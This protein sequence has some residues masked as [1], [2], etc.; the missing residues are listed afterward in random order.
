MSQNS[1]KVFLYVIPIFGG[2]FMLAWPAGLQLTFSIT[3]LLAATQ[4][5]LF[6]SDRF[7]DLVGMQLKPKPNM[8]NKQHI[9]YQAPKSTPSKP[10]TETGALGTL[11]GAVSDIMKVGEKYAPK[12]KQKAQNGRLTEAEKRYAEK[13]EKRRQREFAQEEGMRREDQAR[14]ERKQEQA[15]R[16]QEREARLRRRAEKK[17]KRSQ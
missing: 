5:T 14:S 10:S 13:Y 12:P 1:R 9:Q 11:K 17:A 2:V 15:V 3:S 16:E 7:R 4:A 6:G 8:P